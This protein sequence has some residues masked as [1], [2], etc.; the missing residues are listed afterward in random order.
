MLTDPI[1]DMLTRI[2][3]ALAV[4]KTEVCL[5]FSKIKLALGKILEKEG[6]INKIERD[7]A[8]TRSEEL[9]IVLKYGVNDK[10]SIQGLKRVSKPGCRVY[11][12]CD[13]LPIVLS[14]YGIAIVSTPKGLMSGKEARKQGLGGEV[15]CE[16]W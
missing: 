10:P 14:G 9:K 8:A 5:P 1:S 15:I 3:N 11:A 4:G 12:K 7:S 16:I 6:Y 13:K 2:R